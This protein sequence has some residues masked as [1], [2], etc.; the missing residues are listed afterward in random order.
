[1]EVRVLVDA[2]NPI[3]GQQTRTNM[4]YLVY[5]AIDEN[6]RPH[7]VPPLIPQ[8]P[9]EVRRFEEARLR[10]QRRKQERAE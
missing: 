8:T 9:E 5:V 3:T 7:P 2:E 6:H 1:M 4:A 10:Q